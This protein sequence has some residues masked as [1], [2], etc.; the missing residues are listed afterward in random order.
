M[1]MK[2]EFDWFSVLVECMEEHVSAIRPTN[3][4]T[5]WNSTLSDT[6]INSQ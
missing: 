1:K 6:I 3:A 4:V 5:S 2:P